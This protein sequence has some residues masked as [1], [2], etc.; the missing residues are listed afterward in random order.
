[1]NLTSLKKFIARFLLT[2]FL[3]QTVCVDAGLP[4]LD[5]GK[6]EHQHSEH[7]VDHEH[8]FSTEDHSEISCDDNC[9]CLCTH[10]VFLPE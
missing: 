8:K 10:R 9:H 7:A 3:V 1:M 2:L 4:L 5:Q 6:S